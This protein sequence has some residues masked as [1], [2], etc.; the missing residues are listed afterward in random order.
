MSFPIQYAETV[1]LSNVA[2]S[3]LVRWVSQKRCCQRNRF[4]HSI[5]QILRELCKI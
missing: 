4:C 5:V 2:E 1:T 3:Y